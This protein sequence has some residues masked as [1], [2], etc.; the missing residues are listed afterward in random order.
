MNTRTGDSAEEAYLLRGLL[1]DAH[2]RIREL[3]SRLDRFSDDLLTLKL[4]DRRHSN[5]AHGQLKHER[6]R[7]RALSAYSDE[8]Y[9]GQ[10]KTAASPTWMK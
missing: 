3:Q 8:E 2:R 5:A 1:D 9:R 7:D 10:G 4:S 6:R